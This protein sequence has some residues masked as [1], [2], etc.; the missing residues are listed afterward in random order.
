MPIHSKTQLVIDRFF[1]PIHGLAK[2]SAHARHCPEFSDE[3]WLHAGVRRCLEQASS[4]RAFLQEQGPRLLRPP[5]HSTY[6]SALNNAR[7]LKLLRDVNQAV[8]TQARLP[9]RLADIPELDRYECFAIDGHWHKGAAHD[10][11]HNETKMAVGHFYSLDLRS[12]QLRVLATAEVGLHEHDMSALKRINPT[13]LRQDTPQGARVLI[14]YDKAGIDFDFWKRCRVERA[15]YFLSRAKE[16]MA[17]DWIEDRSLDPNDDRNQGVASDRL[18]KLR[19][20]QLMR[21]IAYIEPQKGKS[22][23]FLTNVMDAPACVLAE[24][25]RRRWEVEKAFDEIKN[26]LGE[27]KAWGTSLEARQTQ[28]QFV[29]LTHNL[30]LIYED[31]L[32]REDGVENRAEDRRRQ[33]RQRELREYLEATGRAVSSLVISARRATQRSVKFIRWLR[34][35]LHERLAEQAAVPRLKALYASM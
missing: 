30:L 6:F 20:G 3:D 12:H 8:R 5:A 13:G 7:R 26:K 29:A 28:A 2:V 21:L 33:E 4:G 35:A 15:V 25:Y 32:E 17:Y 14:V 10:P 31:R 9:D 19:D 11:R 24:L 34:H 22:Y 27:K 1:Q 23:A 16:G 18:I